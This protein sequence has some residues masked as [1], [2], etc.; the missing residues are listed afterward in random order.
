MNRDDCM[1]TI[2]LLHAFYRSDEAGTW[3]EVDSEDQS[4]RLGRADDKLSGLYRTP[5]P[6][7]VAT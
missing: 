3:V 2:K 6:A 7:R 5:K 4:S 1:K